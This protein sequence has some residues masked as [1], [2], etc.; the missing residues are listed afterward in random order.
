MKMVAFDALHV[1]CAR[2][3]APQIAFTSWPKK[4]LGK[5]AKNIPSNLI[6]MNCAAFI[7]ACAK[8]RAQ[9]MRSN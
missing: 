8:K 5:T 4:A 9:L 2:R 1:S 7:A 6:S 3:L